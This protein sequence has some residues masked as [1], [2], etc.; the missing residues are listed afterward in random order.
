[1]TNILRDIAE[2]NIPTSIVIIIP[3]GRYRVGASSYRFVTPKLKFTT[4]MLSSNHASYL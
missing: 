3:S 4:K 2:A 1:M